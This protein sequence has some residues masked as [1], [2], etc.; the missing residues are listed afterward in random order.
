[1]AAGGSGGWQRVAAA[2][3]A[4]TTTDLA[5]AVHTGSEQD[6]LQVV[7]IDAHRRRQAESLA[8]ALLLRGW[9]AE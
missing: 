7:G 8:E 5:N 6:V 4:A 3:A 2:A 1:M 9:F